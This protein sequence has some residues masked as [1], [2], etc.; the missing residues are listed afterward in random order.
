MRDCNASGLRA[1]FSLGQAL[2]DLTLAIVAINGWNRLATG[3]RAE[4]GNYQ[5]AT[6]A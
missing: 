1:Q 4:P 6:R 5:P 3:F 2:A